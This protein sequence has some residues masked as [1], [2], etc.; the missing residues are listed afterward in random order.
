MDRRKRAYRLVRS[1]FRAEKDIRLAVE[2]YKTKERRE[3]TGGSRSAFVSD[4]T[5]GKAERL[6]SPVPAVRLDS[7]IVYKPETWLCVIKS[8]YSM[9]K[10][11]ERDIMRRYYAGESIS[12][13]VDSG[14]GYEKPTLYV[15]VRSFE[16]LA[17]EIA[18]QFGLVKVVDT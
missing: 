3:M 5:A 8:T 16:N 15:I 2:E 9:A 4:P 7:W 11:A 18:C 13:M 12:A 1:I 17:V 10:E 6:I 14:C